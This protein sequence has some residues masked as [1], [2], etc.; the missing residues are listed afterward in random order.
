MYFSVDVEM[1]MKLLPPTL[2]PNQLISIVVMIIIVV[3]FILYIVTPKLIES[4]CKLGYIKRLLTQNS[5]FSEVVKV[6][7]N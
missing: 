6:R 3:M 1:R 7:F 5:H 2:N 4:G